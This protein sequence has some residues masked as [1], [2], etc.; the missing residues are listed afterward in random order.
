MLFFEKS[1]FSF[2]LSLS[3]DSLILI[4]MFLLFVFD[5]IVNLEAH[6][7][8]PDSR[9]CIFSAIALQN[10]MFIKFKAMLFGRIIIVNYWSSLG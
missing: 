8:S 10:V 2:P 9:N 1:Q 3:L 5:I 4:S 6:D 7:L